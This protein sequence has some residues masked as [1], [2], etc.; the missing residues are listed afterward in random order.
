MKKHAA[1][2]TIPLLVFIALVLLIQLEFDSRTI[3]APELKSRLANDETLIVQI[4]LEGCPACEKLKQAEQELS[5]ALKSDI[6]TLVVPKSQKET[7]RKTLK[8]LFPSFEFYPSIFA[9]SNGEI[10]SEFDLSTLESFESRFTDWRSK[11]NSAT[12]TN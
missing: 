6:V 7:D 12:M 4:E 3:S 11:L 10:L 2:I 8:A 9:I 5:P 1:L